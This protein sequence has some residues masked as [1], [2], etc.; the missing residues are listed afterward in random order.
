MKSG[1]LHG[2]IPQSTR[3]SVFKSFKKGDLKCIVATNVAA[4]GLDFPEIPIVIQL[5]PP[6]FTESYIHRSGRTGRAGKEGMCVTLY[7]QEQR[8]LF[9][10]IEKEANI[11]VQ[12]LEIDENKF[13]KSA[14]K[15]TN[16]ES[17]NFNSEVSK[18]DISKAMDRKQDL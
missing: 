9:F 17:V 11:K 13:S 1:I 16:K 14:S 6:K 15:F 10:K 18:E 4:R 5:E 3:E 12:E 2:D 8:R 7:D